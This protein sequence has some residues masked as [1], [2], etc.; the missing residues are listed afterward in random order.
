MK[1][2]PIALKM[3]IYR[4][5]EMSEHK[6][7]LENVVRTVASECREAIN[8]L[9][10]IWLELGIKDEQRQTRNDTVITLIKNLLAEMVAEEKSLKCQVQDNVAEFT[11]VTNQLCKDLALPDVQI[12][13]KMSLIELETELRHKVDSLKKEKH[14]RLKELKTLR[15]EEE[16]LCTRLDLPQHELNF[17]GCPAKQQLTELEQN[18][19]YL[20]AEMKKRFDLFKKLQTSVRQLWLDLDMDPYTEFEVEL[21]RGDADETFCLSAANLDKVKALQDQ[22][23]IEH[24][25]LLGE[26]DGLQEQVK[27]LWERL[28][29]DAEERSSF[30]KDN[31]DLSPKTAR[32]F[33]QEL[34]RLQE[35]KRLHMAKFIDNIRKE[36]VALWDKCCFG[37]DQ[38][39]DFLPYYEDVFTDEAL[40]LHEHQVKI[41]NNYYHENKRIFKLIE[42]RETSWKNKLDFEDKS[43]NADR[44]FTARGDAMLKE[45][46][47]RAAFEK[48]LPKIEEELKKCL[49]DWEKDDESFFLYNGMRYLDRITMQH[50]AWEDLKADK[51]KERNRAKQENTKKEMVFGS[52]PSA[53]KR[54]CNGT[55]VKSPS[56]HR[57]LDMTHTP[58][59]YTHSSIH[60]TPKKLG[61]TGNK[62]V[63]KS[64]LKSKSRT[65]ATARR[66]SNR[67]NARQPTRGKENTTFQPSPAT[68]LNN[69]KLSFVSG[70]VT[71]AK[72]AQPGNVGSYQEFS[73]GIVSP[74]C[75]SSFV[76]KSPNGSIQL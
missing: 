25:K 1:E 45:A 11:K 48:G 33:K 35:L 22:L 40:T 58:S 60:P 76:S 39:Q 42:K 49:H 64:A 14:E 28:E 27:A 16:K 69:T 38:R 71:P 23:E 46:K 43:S 65:V 55:P 74:N 62:Q 59:K 3:D 70:H 8:V 51:K 4:P 73:I 52:K 36:L 29:I 54:K 56:K 15:T 5:D 19:G 24:R 61:A 63:V 9:G 47:M 66:R 18:I 31:S 68:R 44:L 20:Q 12:D 21:C 10:K 37:L 7:L 6:L 75:R 41:M 53:I 50:E 30:L 2:L 13:P 67:L 72:T 32:A 26:I 34:S 17:V 57:R